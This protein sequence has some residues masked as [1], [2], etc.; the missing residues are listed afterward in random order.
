[1]SDASHVRGQTPDTAENH[2]F[3]GSSLERAG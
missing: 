1:V 3:E 2:S